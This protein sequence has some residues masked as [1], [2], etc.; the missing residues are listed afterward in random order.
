ME[1]IREL[2]LPSKLDSLSRVE[3]FALEL[4]RL[5]QLSDE[6]YNDVMLILTEAVTNAIIHG[7]KQDPSKKVLITVK[8]DNQILTIIVKDE[9]SGFD[10]E[11]VPNPL[12]EENLLKTG[13]R[14]IY[15]INQY[16]DYVHYSEKGNQVTIIFEL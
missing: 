4:K 11:K 6:R 2:S 5:A 1:E 16:A 12:K 10:P 15:L 9:G 14:G 7:N 3:Q 13:G 8:L